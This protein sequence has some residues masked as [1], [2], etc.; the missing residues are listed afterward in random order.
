MLEKIKTKTNKVQSR[1]LKQ[2]RKGVW[3][4]NLF[5]NKYFKASILAVLA[6]SVLFWTISLIL[7]S[8]SYAK[9]ETPT[10][11][12]INAGKFF[13]KVNW[14]GQ[15]T[16]T[17]G[18]T[19]KFTITRS[20]KADP[21]ATQNF[22]EVTSWSFTHYVAQRDF[23]SDIGKVQQGDIYYTVTL[24]D[25]K[26]TVLASGNSKVTAPSPIT[27]TYGIQLDTQKAKVAW[28]GGFCGPLIEKSCKYKIIRSLRFAEKTV[29][30]Q[31]NYT[32]SRGKGEII[33][34]GTPTDEDSLAKLVYSVQLVDG[35]GNV[36]AVALSPKSQKQKLEKRLF[37]GSN[38]LLALLLGKLLLLQPLPG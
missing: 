32:D 1:A 15:V 18:S 19:C 29:I 17:A 26:N 37:L 38:N 33:D 36:L 3:I 6:F 8:S 10:E 20:D 21:I 11:A 31:I 2:E 27:V 23:G 9:V 28:T 24:T 13:F 25:E 7:A 34:E 12:D 35:Q 5:S 4:K 22:S 16:C 30:K 14:F